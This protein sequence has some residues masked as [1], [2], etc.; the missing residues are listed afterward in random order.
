MS[1]RSGDA[2]RRSP[3]RKIQPSRV[4][5]CGLVN[6]RRAPWTGGSCERI[7]VFRCVSLRSPLPSQAVTY[8]SEGASRSPATKA[9]RRPALALA[10]R[11]WR[12]PPTTTFVEPSPIAV[13]TRCAFPRSPAMKVT[14]A[15]SLDQI[16]PGVAVATGRSTATRPRERDLASIGGPRLRAVLEVAVGELFRLAGSDVDDE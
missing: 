4:P 1:T 5:P 10:R 2:P 8:K 9:I 14:L 12:S 13:R 11:I 15:L 6:V 3:D 16:G 7:S